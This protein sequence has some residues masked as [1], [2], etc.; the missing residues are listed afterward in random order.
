MV[1]PFYL[2]LVLPAVFLNTPGLEFSPR[3]ALVPVVN[4]ALMVRQAI[5][6]SYPALEI[7]LTVLS[8]TAVIAALIA[9]A[10]VVLRFEDFVIG[11]YGGSLGTFVRQRLLKKGKGQ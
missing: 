2:L 11:S 8:S 9:M 6:G 4:I 5:T 3:L 7:G 10:V 1:T